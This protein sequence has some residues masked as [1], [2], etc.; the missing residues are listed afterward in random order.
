MNTK[1]IKIDPKKL[2]LLKINA[3]FMR[4]ETFH[5]LVD[6]VK[7]D[8]VLTQ[9]P[10]AALLDYYE[11]GDEIQ[12]WED[13]TPKY[14]VLSGNHR[15][16]AAIAAKLDVIEIQVT[17]DP[18]T[19]DQRKA[20]Q[21]SH[22]SIT[23]EDDPAT[24]KYIYESIDDPDYRVYS[25]LDDKQLELIG[26]DRADTLN[27]ANL[28]F[29]PITMLFLPNEI[30]QLN[31]VWD[32]V[33][34]EVKGAKGG[35]LSR[36]A[37]YDRVMDAMEI[38]SMAYGV[39]NTATTMIIILEIFSRHFDDLRDGWLDSDNEPFAGAGKIPIQSVLGTS[40]LPAK[41]GAKVVKAIK[42]M[43][44]KGGVSPGEWHK[45]LDQWADD[46]LLKE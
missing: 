42:K 12:Y 43:E 24:L 8:G 6:N 38:T 14:E 7:E 40:F 39:K 21:L 9:L 22:N 33:K 32:K 35:W 15:V 5:R 16:K 1:V 44:N 30:E 37:E 18:R 20:I 45:A 2:I 27:E 36:W 19:R 41:T 46:Y 31:Q 29:Q 25:G 28:A 23:G 34:Q 11:P 10:F 3:R 13:G 4:H 26:D 17:D